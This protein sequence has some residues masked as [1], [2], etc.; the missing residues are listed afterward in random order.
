MIRLIHQDKSKHW[1]C[2][3]HTSNNHW[4]RVY[5][6]LQCLTYFYIYVQLDKAKIATSVRLKAPT[7]SRSHHL[8]IERN[9]LLNTLARF[10]SHARQSKLSTCIKFHLNMMRGTKFTELRRRNT[11]RF[12]VDWQPRKTIKRTCTSTFP[13]L[14]LSKGIRVHV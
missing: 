8:D 6:V 12:F 7:H 4:L 9:C 10:R 2:C 14:H 11:G 13:L 5:W 3:L 1:K